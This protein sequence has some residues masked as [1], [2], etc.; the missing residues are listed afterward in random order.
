MPETKEHTQK[1]KYYGMTEKMYMEFV[2]DTIKQSEK[3]EH[4][5]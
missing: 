1:R 5:H 3:R 4:R 2:H